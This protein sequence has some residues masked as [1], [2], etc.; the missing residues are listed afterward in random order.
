MGKL[1]L[2][3]LAAIVV[4]GVLYTIAYRIAPFK[5]TSGP[6]TPVQNILCW[7]AMV[8][9]PVQV[10]VLLTAGQYLPIG[11]VNQHMVASI[12]FAIG[13]GL[14]SILAMVI[15]RFFYKKHAYALLLLTFNAATAIF[16]FMAAMILLFSQGVAQ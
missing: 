7:L 11:V 12:N 6:L 8:Y 2:F 1:F 16:Y 3:I 4:T 14:L 13:H 9:V 10:V 5:K 15:A